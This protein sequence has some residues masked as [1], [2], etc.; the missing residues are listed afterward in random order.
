MAMRFELAPYGGNIHG[1]KAA[2]L[3]YFKKL[4]QDLS[5]AECALLAGL[6][7]SPTYLRPDRYPQRAKDRRDRVLAS[8][9]ENKFITDEEYKIAKSDPVVAGNYAFPFKAPHFTRFVIH[10]S[11]DQTVVTSLDPDLQHFAEL[12]LKDMVSHLE[13]DGVSN[14]AVVIIENKTGKIRAMAGSVD[15]FSDENSGQINGALSLRCPG[16]A[17]LADGAFDSGEL[18]WFVDDKF[19][20]KSGAGQKVFWNMIDGDHKITVVDA[21]GRSSFVKIVVR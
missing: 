21:N 1:V 3:R 8:M 13:P 15:F 20:Q 11:K 10:H 2:S 16:S 7:Q 4:P 14:G 19:Y 9:L 6:P 17:L 12:S 18:F 5:L